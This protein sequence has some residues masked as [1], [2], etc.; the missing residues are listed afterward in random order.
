[1]TDAQMI[2]Q[3]PN[4]PASVLP[5]P[6]SPASTDPNSTST[7]T[8]DTHGEILSQSPKITET[9]Q[10]EAFRKWIE[11]EVLKIMKQQVSNKDVSQQ[12][13]QDMANR[14]LDII[15]P[16]MDIQELFQN[17]IKLNDGYPEF[18]SVVIKLIKEYEH[19][20]KKKAVEQVAALV[21]SGKLE[22]AQDVVKKVLEYKME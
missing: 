4:L 17:A 13:I 5:P 3:A 9:N 1:M 11:M 6:I 16:G 14:V 10:A 2:Q 8:Q 18:D 7:I 12:R 15:Q 22:Q 20:Y 19:K 21:R